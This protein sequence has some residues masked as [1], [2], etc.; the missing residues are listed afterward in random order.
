MQQLV[1]LF[2][3]LVFEVIQIIDIIPIKTVNIMSVKSE[4]VQPLKSINGGFKEKKS[5]TWNYNFDQ[6]HKS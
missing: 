4:N 5:L 3:Q 1:M 2:L 6:V